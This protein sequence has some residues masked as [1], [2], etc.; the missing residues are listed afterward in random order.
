[1]LIYFI[2]LTILTTI[3]FGLYI[4]KLEE[5][6]ENIKKQQIIDDCNRIIELCEKILNK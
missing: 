6:I 4:I 1:M 2:T 3:S 5:E